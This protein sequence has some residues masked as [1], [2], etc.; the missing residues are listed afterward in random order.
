MNNWILVTARKPAQSGGPG[1]LSSPLVRVLLD[2][3]EEDEDFLINGKWV[4]YCE[5]QIGTPHVIAWK[6]K[7]KP[8]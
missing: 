7:G 1:K 5:K 3:G 4:F 8:L 6:E 2:T